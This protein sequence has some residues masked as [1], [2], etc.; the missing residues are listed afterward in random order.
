ML[1]GDM[2]KVV[3]C[4]QGLK[5]WHQCSLYGNGVVLVMGLEGTSWL[6]DAL[7]EVLC[8]ETLHHSS[9]LLLP[10]VPSTFSVE[11]SPL[12]YSWCCLACFPFCQVVFEADCTCFRAQEQSRHS[13]I[14]CCLCERPQRQSMPVLFQHAGH[15]S[16]GLNSSGGGKRRA[17]RRVR[18]VGTNWVR[19]VG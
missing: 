17:R 18:R 4:Q 3:T 13:S 7:V 2:V 9:V 15:Q 14:R 8:H 6:V 16:W 11:N 12:A 19:E 1:C 5:W 10:S